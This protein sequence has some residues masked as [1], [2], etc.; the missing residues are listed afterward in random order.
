MNIEYLC[1]SLKKDI[2]IRALRKAMLKGECTVNLRYT[3][4]MFG[5]V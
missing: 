5:A 4:K 2:H 3:L 1:G